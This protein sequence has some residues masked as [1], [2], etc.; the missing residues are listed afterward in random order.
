M[1]ALCIEKSSKDLNMSMM[2]EM[3]NLDAGSAEIPLPDPPISEDPSSL[4]EVRGAI[5]KLKSGKA[6]SICGIPAELLKASGEP[7]GV[8]IP[9]WKGKRDRWD[10]SIHRGITLVSIPS[11]VLAHILLRCIRNYLLRHQRTEQSGFTAGMSTIDHILT[12]QVIVEH[13]REFGCRLFAAYIDL[14][15]EFDTVYRESLWE[16]LRL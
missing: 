15:K 2:M 5:S 11:K 13:H 6:A 7:M 3:F 12:L 4:T 8:V 10:C 9:L 16:T 14:K 1:G